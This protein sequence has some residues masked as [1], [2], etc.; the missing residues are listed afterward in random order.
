MNREELS[1]LRDALGV[2]LAWPDSVRAEIARWLVAP[3]DLADKSAPAPKTVSET[4]GAKA[5]AAENSAS[6]PGNGR[7]H[8][9]RI[10]PLARS[11]RPRLDDAAIELALAD[12]PLSAG[13]L[14]RSLGRPLMGTKRE[15]KAMAER[16]T[17]ERTAGGLWQ[18]AGEANP[19]TDARTEPRPM[20]APL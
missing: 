9:P 19:P 15:L 2:V 17:V 12:K 18:L 3:T 6:M 11:A 4:N 1:T 14:S 16:G 10:A 13:A 5:G 20:S 7:D 8:P